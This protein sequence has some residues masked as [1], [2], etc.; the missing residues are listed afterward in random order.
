MGRARRPRSHLF[1]APTFSVRL[2]SLDIL[3]PPWRALRAD[4]GDILYRTSVPL[5]PLTQPHEEARF[6]STVC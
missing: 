2:T 6:R 1:D 5:L 4:R 3:R